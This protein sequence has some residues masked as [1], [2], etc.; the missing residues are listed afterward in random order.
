[1]SRSGP[2]RRARCTLPSSARWWRLT[3]SRGRAWFLRAAMTGRARSRSSTA[4]GASQSTRAGPSTSRIGGARRSE[5]STRRASCRPSRAAAAGRTPAPARRTAS[6][7]PPV[8]SIRKTS[9]STRAATSISWTA[10]TTRSE[11]EA[12]PRPAVLLA[13]SALP[14]QPARHLLAALL[15]KAGWPL[16]ADPRA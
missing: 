7:R 6:A 16:V 5:R 8:F 10:G 11:K 15:S 3:R 9:R 14:V 2:H 4:R 13:T 12:S 1:M